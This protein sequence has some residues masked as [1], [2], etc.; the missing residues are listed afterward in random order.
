MKSL[1]GQNRQAWEI[2][3]L[4]RLSASGPEGSKAV[5]YIAAKKVKLSFAAQPTGAR[6][7]PTG[8]TIGPKE[9]QINP[10]QEVAT[11]EAKDA[12][13][14]SLIAHEAKHYEQGL[15]TALSVYGELEAWQ[16]QMK[17]LRD[18]GSPPKSEAWSAIE[19]LKLSHDPK[20]L[21]EAARLMKQ[22]DP[23]YRIN[24][25]PLNPLNVL[26][27]LRPKNKPLPK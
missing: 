13:S 11:K 2:K 19:K 14:I 10:Q 6:W 21:Q 7:T 26:D 18:L 22:V 15:A 3:V 20:I 25:L 16:L 8:M 5:D 12:W 1:N 23:N 4:S 9:I 24:L 17:V 27:Y